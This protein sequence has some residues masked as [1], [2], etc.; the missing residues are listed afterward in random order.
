MLLNDYL[1]KEEIKKEIKDILEF[2]ENEGTT[3]PN[4]WD[5]MKAV[6]RGKIIVLSASRKK[7]ERAYISSFTAHLKDLE[8]KEA[9]TLQRHRWE[10]IISG[11]NS[12]KSKHKE[13]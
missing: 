12:I 11:M 3:Y 4:L 8:Q 13:L 5:T 9:K 1:F 2:N 10:E 7:V 6:L